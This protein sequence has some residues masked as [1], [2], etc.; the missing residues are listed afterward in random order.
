[1]GREDRSWVE[2]GREATRGGTVTQARRV[3]ASFAG[4]FLALPSVCYVLAC[5][6][7]AVAPPTAA[8]QRAGHGV[9]GST[10]VTL[11]RT[12]V[13]PSGAESAEDLYR[14]AEAQQ[15]AGEHAAA[16]QS[17]ERLLSLDPGGRWEA[18]A[19][20]GA[21]IACDAS[22]EEDALRERALQ[23][24]LVVLQRYPASPEAAEAALRATRLA[25][26]LQHWDLAMTTTDALLATHPTA[27][28]HR[29]LAHGVRAL[30]L[31][32][33][34]H[35][36]EAE[37]DLLR[38]VDLANSVA[39]DLPDLIP[40]DWAPAFFAAGESKRLASEAIVFVP[41]PKDFGAALESRAQL[42]LDAQREY[43]LVLR[44]RD[45]HWSTMAGV[46]IGEMY[47]SLHQ[48]LMAIPPPPNAD[49]PERRAL[50]EAALRLRYAVLLR[51]ASS[52]VEHTLAMA[53]RTGE[54]G[55]WVERARAA[56]SRLVEAV[57]AEDAALART[58]WS[59]EVI[60]E[61]LRL[62]TKGRSFSVPSQKPSPTDPKAAHSAAP[63]EPAKAR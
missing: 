52:L 29:I 41:V 11:D 48:A 44:A 23:H 32:E 31:L 53:E 30:A 55:P 40:A 51:K 59:R 13:S 62:I 3:T 57:S 26:Y 24:L 47:E 58:P 42:L 25:A 33:R 14:R 38:A 43:S 45:S 2:D 27:L 36:Q 21:A 39:D 50:F 56:R 9:D 49:T 20:L 5:T 34:G 37:P 12:L 8:P 63:R 4:R 17:F 28:S 15:R 1:M 61:A 46:R 10:T 18:P 7:A 60:E 22:S 19:R 16:L 54:Q 6:P 35:V